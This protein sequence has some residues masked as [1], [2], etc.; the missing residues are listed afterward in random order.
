ML[1]INVVYFP[2]NERS[3]SPKSKSPE[4]KPKALGLTLFWSGPPTQTGRSTMSIP[5]TGILFLM[6]FNLGQD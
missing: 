4:S 6:R 3:P 1:N 2:R 5:R